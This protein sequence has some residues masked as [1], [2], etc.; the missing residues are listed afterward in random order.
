MRSGCEVFRPCTDHVEQRGNEHRLVHYAALFFG[1][2]SDLSE[3]SRGYRR[4]PTV[5]RR[6]R[7]VA[8]GDSLCFAGIVDRGR[9]AGV[10][11]VQPGLRRI[12]LQRDSSLHQ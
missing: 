12:G 8:L 11:G 2:S 3:L 9:S 5:T 6:R 10:P 1:L 4:A 7:K